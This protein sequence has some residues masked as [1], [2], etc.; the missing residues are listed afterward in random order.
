MPKDQWDEESAICPKCGERVCDDMSDVHDEGKEYHF[1]C[2]DCDVEFHV[3]VYYS[4][5]YRS[6]MP[7]E[8]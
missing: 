5:R 7:Q 3:S 6:F 1:W 8:S 4:T 2:E